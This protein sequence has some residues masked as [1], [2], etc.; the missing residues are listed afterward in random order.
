[1]VYV[2][3]CWL[4]SI[5]SRGSTY[6][7]HLT[8]RSGLVLF[9]YLCRRECLLGFRIGRQCEVYPMTY[10]NTGLRRIPKIMATL[11][12]LPQPRRE[13]PNNAFTSDPGT[14]FKLCSITM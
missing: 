9:Q 7:W 3:V 13:A 14:L 4:R 12:P 2:S 1:M 8:R 10:T 6:P 5:S 11:T